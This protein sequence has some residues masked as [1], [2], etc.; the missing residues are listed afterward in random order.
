MLRLALLC[1]V[2]GFGCFYDRAIFEVRGYTG[3]SCRAGPA[4]SGEDSVRVAA[5]SVSRIRSLVAIAL[6]G[7]QL[8][9]LS[10][11]ADI[12][13]SSLSTGITTDWFT[14]PRL[15][16]RRCRAL[17]TSCAGGL[18]RYRRERSY[19]RSMWPSAMLQTWQRSPRMHSPQER[20]LSLAARVVVVHV[21]ALPLFEWLVTHAAG[22]L[23][24]LR[25]PVEVTPA[26][27][28]SWL[29]GRF[30]IVLL[31][32]LRCLVVRVNAPVSP[33]IFHILGRRAV[34]SVAG[35]ARTCRLLSRHPLAT[36]AAAPLGQGSSP[37]RPAFRL[38][39]PH[40][41]LSSLASPC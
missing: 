24:R 33:A 38:V 1:G 40:P 26:L 21:D 8:A 2:L 3:W 28:H 7:L 11:R 15:I 41:A 29:S 22:V 12:G 16:R 9:H 39:L 35:P 17:A 5:A 10:S 14:S 27:A 25:S 20:H 31:A 34:S 32:G 13:S 36:P 4:R 23:L 18:S 6:P 19:R 30:A 37:A